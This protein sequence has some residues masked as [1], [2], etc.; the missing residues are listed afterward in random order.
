MG[1]YSPGSSQPSKETQQCL[2]VGGGQLMRPQSSCPVWPVGSSCTSKVNTS[3]TS[4]VGVGQ[5]PRAPLGVSHA[6]PGL[7]LPAECHG[8][9]PPASSLAGA[10]HSLWT[11]S[12]KLVLSTALSWVC[13][14]TLRPCLVHWTMRKESLDYVKNLSCHI[15]NK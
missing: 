5:K 11:P 12:R 4:C 3:Q 7:Q 15:E 13:L 2:L 6:L 1:S 8:H 9:G 10:P 14:Y